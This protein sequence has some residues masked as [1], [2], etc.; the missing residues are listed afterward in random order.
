MSD[1]SYD[2]LQQSEDDECQHN[3][4]SESEIQWPRENLRI[5]KLQ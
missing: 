4:S 1:L 3:C 2:V 5:L